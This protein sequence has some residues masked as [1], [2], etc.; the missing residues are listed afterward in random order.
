MTVRVLRPYADLE[1]VFEKLEYR[2]SPADAFKALPLDSDTVHHVVRKDDL[3]LFAQHEFKVVLNGKRFKPRYQKHLDDLRL[4]V[5]TR[6]STLRREIVLG[7]YEVRSLPE[8]ISLPSTQLALTGHRDHLPIQFSLVAVSVIRG[9]KA[10][11]TQRASRLAELRVV[12]LNS[13][14]GA[15]FPYKRV[16]AEDLE[17]HHLPAETGVHLELI[18]GVEELLK[19]TDTPAHNLFEVWIHEN[20]WTALQN[21]RSAVCSR[22]RMLMVTETT[23]MLL[24]SAVLPCLKN[25]H[26]IEPGSIVGQLV[27]FIEKQSHLPN[28]DLRAR[29]KEDGNLPEITPYLQHAFRYVTSASKIQDEDEEES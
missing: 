7:E 3:R 6:D 2:A 20:L 29:L 22:M 12:L 26:A 14:G 28:G 11:P 15:S 1:G 19:D 17:S 4:Y 25:G 23:A 24:L 13:S 16:T 21:D 5:L 8:V 27:T 10:F 9:D 18:C